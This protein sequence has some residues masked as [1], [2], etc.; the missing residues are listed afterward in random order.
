MTYYCG[1]KSHECGRVGSKSLCFCGHKYAQHAVQ[2]TKKKISSK[3]QT[4]PCKEFKNIPQRAEECG[5]YWLPRR[6]E[7][8]QSEWRAKCKCKLPHDQHNPLPPYTAKGCQ[9]FYSDFACISCDCRWEDHETLFEFEDERRAQKK[10]VGQAYVPLSMNQEL[11]DLVFNTDRKALPQY[12]RE[13]PPLH[14]LTAPKPP[15]I[16]AYG[17]GM[18]A[19]HQPPKSIGR[20]PQMDDQGDDRFLDPNMH[21]DYLQDRGF[22]VQVSRRPANPMMGEDYDYQPPKNIVYKPAA[23]QKPAISSQP[24]PTHIAANAPGNKPKPMAAQKP[25]G[26]PSIAAKTTTTP[27]QPSYPKPGPAGPSKGFRGY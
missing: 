10:K 3:C 19:A 2:A 1:K 8:K 26:T 17:A 11:H 7:F 22:G 25:A 23:A 13:K 21:Q 14:A 20:S 4:C 12:N 16:G 15:M 5:M 18:H 9:G 27:S 6:K 24:K